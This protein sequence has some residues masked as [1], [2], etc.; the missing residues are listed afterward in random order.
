MSDIERESTK[1][2]KSERIRNNAESNKKYHVI[3]YKFSE[4]EDPYVIEQFE[5]NLIARGYSIGIPYSLAYIKIDSKFNG[6][7][8]SWLFGYL[9][10]L[11]SLIMFETDVITPLKD[12]NGVFVSV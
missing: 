3:A 9:P 8:N 1:P 11:N 12:R 7:P 4:Y 5:E 2:I 10:R 6:V